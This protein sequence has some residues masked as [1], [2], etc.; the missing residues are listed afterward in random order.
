MKIKA[1]S[2]LPLLVLVTNISASAQGLDKGLAHF[3][4]AVK[5]NQLGKPVYLK[6]ASDQVNK[7]LKDFDLK[8]APTDIQGTNEKSEGGVATG[9][10]NK[11]QSV[12]VGGS[13]VADIIRNIKLPTDY[14]I[15]SVEMSLFA[16]F[17]SP[18]P[19]SNL[20]VETD[21]RLRSLNKK[22]FGGKIKIY[23]ALQQ[24]DLRPQ[25]NGPCLD[26]DGIQVDGSAKDAPVICLSIERLSG[27]TED[28]AQRQ[29]VS[30]VAH[31][32]SHMLGTDEAE[33]TILQ[34]MVR[35]NLSAHAVRNIPDLVK[36]YFQDLEVAVT[37]AQSLNVLARKNQVQAACTVIASLQV[38]LG[39][40][41]QQTMRSSFTSG[42]MF[43]RPRDAEV[44][45]GTFLK[46]TN[47][48]TSCMPLNH[49]K[50]IGQA[51]QGRNEMSLQEF[52]RIVSKNSQYA[53][54]VPDWKIRRIRA[55]SES[56]KLETAEI[57]Q[58]LQVLRKSF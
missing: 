48:L 35:G 16:Y 55:G 7:N 46:A 37:N 13:E 54:Q 24:A 18:T 21:Q 20:D 56:L 57:L 3:D 8:S 17:R 41:L 1:I 9:G 5:F 19:D 58:A 22:L 52:N 44:L 15:R 43:L 31:E 50:A 2:L 39:T 53:M 14:A 45:A 38:Q 47:V 40:L 4:S 51:F 28:S 34:S 23:E 12:Q 10:G 30:L 36:N 29:L 27:M 33:A 42:I 32:V 25:L 6:G 49:Y 26:R 11:L